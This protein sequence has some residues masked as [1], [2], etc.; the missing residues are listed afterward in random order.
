MSSLDDFQSLVSRASSDRAALDQLITALSA[1]LRKSASWIL[2]ENRGHPTLNP[3]GLVH[4]LY[5]RLATSTSPIPR[6]AATFLRAAATAMGN[7]VIDYHRSKTAAK[8][9]GRLSRLDIDD[10]MLAY[11]ATGMDMQLLGEAIGELRQHNSLAG[12]V[13]ALHEL[14]GYP[15]RDIAR[16]LDVQPSKIEQ[17]YR[18]ATRFLQAYIAEEGS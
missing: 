6:D 12:D 18:L 8:R 2:R 5:I 10:V 9:G 17:L 3:T 14:A 1:D 4:S 7:L 11:E 16:I 15:L 13:F